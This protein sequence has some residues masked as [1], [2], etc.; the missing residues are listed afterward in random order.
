MFVDDGRWTM[1]DAMM[2]DDDAMMDDGRIWTN[3]GDYSDL[4]G[5]KE[6]LQGSAKYD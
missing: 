1:D 2:D 4:G 3:H 5:E 6:K